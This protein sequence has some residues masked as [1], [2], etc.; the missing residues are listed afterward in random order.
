MKTSSGYGIGTKALSLFLSIL[1]AFSVV[2][3]GIV[4]ATE[5][6]AGAAYATSYPKTANRLREFYYPADT[7][8]VYE[9]AM[10]YS[11]KDNNTARKGLVN[12]G[13]TPVGK[14]FNTEDKHNS[15]YVWLG[16]KYQDSPV[17]TVRAFRVEV[18]GS[19]P[20]SYYSAINGNN[21][22]FYKVGSGEKTFVPNVLDGSVDLNSGTGDTA[23]L[24]LYATTDFNAGPPITDI[25]MF[26]DDDAS[27]A[28]SALEFLGYVSPNG[29][30]VTSFDKTA[31]CIDMNKDCSNGDYLYMG[32]KSSV[33]LVSTDALRA[34]M[35]EVAPMINNGQTSDELNAAMNYA[36]GIINDYN[37][38]SSTRRE[39]YSTVYDQEEID[40]ACENLKYQKEQVIA[41]S[42]SSDFSFVVPEA[43]YLDPNSNTF[44]TYINNNADGSVTQNTNGSTGKIYYTYSGADTASISY[45]FYDTSLTPITSDCSISL[46]S[47]SIAS[48]DA[49][50]VTINSG[51]TKS[52]ESG[53]IMW[54]LKYN[55]KHDNNVEKKAVAFTYIYAP[56]ITSVATAS[57]IED[58]HGNQ[59]MAWWSGVHSS[60][61]SKPTLTESGSDSKI[62]MYYG[63]RYDASS[64]PTTYFAPMVDGVGVYSTSSSK[65]SNN[66]NITEWFSAATVSGFEKAIYYSY[67]GYESSTDTWRTNAVTGYSALLTVDSSRYTNTSYIPNL[68][69]GVMCTDFYEAQTQRV[70]LSK[71]FYNVNKTDNNWHNN[72]L[73]PAIDN[74]TTLVSSQGNKRGKIYDNTVSYTWE[75]NSTGD[76]MFALAAENSDK[77]SKTWHTTRYSCSAVFQ[78]IK[79][80]KI[81]K[82]SLRKSVRT[83]ISLMP[84]FGV[85]GYEN[86][87]LK[88]IYFGYDDTWKDFSNAFKNASKALTKLDGSCKVA[89]LKKDLEDAI[90][91]LKTQVYFNVNHDNIGTNLFAP[92]ITPSG[93]SCGLTW[94]YDS[95]SEEITVNGTQSGDFGTMIASPFIPESGAT[96]KITVTK[97]GGS[98]TPKGCLVIEAIDVKGSNMPTRTYIAFSSSTAATWTF[99]GDNLKYCRAIKLWC[100]NNGGNSFTNFKFTIK[101]EKT[102][103]TAYSFAARQFIIGPATT[104]NFSSLPDGSR[105]AAR[106]GY[107]F[108]GWSTSPYAESGS[109][110]SVRVGINTTVY[111]SWLRNSSKL[112]VN[113][114]GGSWKGE[115]GN[116]TIEMQYLDELTIPEPYK[117]GYN[118]NG[119]EVT[120]SNGTLTSSTGET[121]TYVFGPTKDAVDTIKAKW[122]PITYTVSYNANGGS[123]TTASSSH[124]Y[125]TAKSLNANNFTRNYTATFK[126]NDGVTADSTGTIVSKFLGWNTA[127]D[128]TGT[129]Y[130]NNTNQG[131]VSVTNLTTV[132]GSTVPLYAK[133]EGAKLA[134]LPAPTRTG[135]TFD[136][137]YQNPEFTGSKVTTSTVFTKDATLYAR[138]IININGL[139]IDSHSGASQN[140]LV[141]F[142]NG[143]N[144]AS[145]GSTTN[146]YFEGSY[147]DDKDL[148]FSVQAQNTGKEKTKQTDTLEVYLVKG[149]KYKI[150]FSAPNDGTDFYVFKQ[151]TAMDVC[152]G[153]LKNP[154]KNNTT[155]LYDYSATFTVGYAS[156]DSDGGDRTWH[157]AKYN[158]DTYQLTGIY[159]M[160]MSVNAETYGNFTVSNMRIVEVSQD[161]GADN[162]ITQ[163]YGTTRNIPNPIRTG[164][165]FVNWTLTSGAGGSLS[166]TTGSN[167]RTT[168]SVY[169]FGPDKNKFDTI[170]ANW[171]PVTYS[172]SYNANRGSGTVH[173]S[174]TMANSTHTY[175][176]AKNLTENTYT[177]TNTVTY[178]L[179]GGSFAAGVNNPETVYSIFSGWNTKA[180][181]SGTSYDDL[182]SVKN[183]SSTQGAT[184]PLYAK[185]TYSGADCE[186]PNKTGYIFSG[187]YTGDNGTG[188]LVESDTLISQDMTLYAKWTPIIYY[189]Y[190]DY[191]KGSGSSTPTG[192]TGY[193]TATYDQFA[194]LTANGFSRA[195]YTFNGWNSKADGTGTSYTD[196]QSVKNLASTQGATVTLYAKWTANT[197]SVVYNANRGSSANGSG[198]TATSTHTYDT[199]K[200]LTAN[201]YSRSNT[202][203]FD[204]KG[205][206][207]G[208]SVASRT[209][210][211]T[212]NGWN[213]NAAGTGT[214]YTNKQ[215]VKNLASNQGATVNLYAKWTYGTITLPTPTKTGYL[216]EGWYKNSDCS[217]TAVTAETTYSTNLTLYAKWKAIRYSVFYE[218][219]RTD[220]GDASTVAG[221]TTSS[222]DKAYDD[223]FSLSENGFTRTI[224]LTYDTKGGDAITATTHSTEFAHW[225]GLTF[226]PVA[227]QYTY[228]VYAAQASV[229]KLNKDNNG[230]TTL[231]AEWEDAKVTLPTPVKPGYTFNY[232]CTDSGCTTA[233]TLTDGKYS[234][235][236]NTTIYAKW[237]ENTYNISYTCDGA[238]D[239]SSTASQTGIRYTEAKKLNANGFSRYYVITYNVNGSAADPVDA[240]TPSAASTKAVQSFNG[241]QGSVYNPSTRTYAVQTFSTSDIANNTYSKLAEG[242]SAHKT[243][244]LKATWSTGK[245]SALPT[246]PTRTGFTFDGW[247]TTQNFQSGTKVSTSTEFTSDTTVYAKWNENT[248]NISFNGNGN[249]SGTTAAMNGVR[250]TEEKTLTNGFKKEYTVTFRLNDSGT[251]VTAADTL[252]STTA[253]A[254]YVFAGW[255]ED[256]S[257]NGTPLLENNAKVSRLRTGS[258]TSTAVSFTAQWTP[259]SITL[260][261]PTR[262]GYVFGGWYK[263]ATDFSEENKIGNGGASYTPT[264]SIIIYARWTAINYTIALDFNKASVSPAT[265]QRGTSGTVTMSATFDKAK[266]LTE[267][268][269][270]RVGYK[271]AGWALTPSG[272]VKFSDKE[273]VKNLTAL[274]GATVTKSDGTSVVVTAENAREL[275]RDGVTVTLYA[276]WTPLS[277][278]I[279]YNGNGSSVTGTME[280][281]AVNYSTKSNLRMCSF[282]NTFTMDYNLNDAVGDTKAVLSETQRTCSYGFKGWA[283]TPTGA[284]VYT[285]GVKVNGHLGKSNF[286]AS[287]YLEG[288]D[289]ATIVVKDS[290]RIKV[291]HDGVW[292][293]LYAV[294]DYAEITLPTPTRTGYDFLGWYDNAG[295][296]GDALPMR[297]TP[298]AGITL[299]A[300]WAAHTYTIEYNGNKGNG[301]TTV[302]GTMNNSISATY[303]I[304]STL[305]QNAFSRDGYTFAGWNTKADGTGTAYANKATNVRNLTTENGV[306]VQLYAQWTPITYTIT[307]HD[308]TAEDKTKVQTFTFDKA[309]NLTYFDNPVTIKLTLYIEAG[310]IQESDGAVANLDHWKNQNGTYAYAPGASVVN[311]RTAPGNIDLYAD[312]GTGGCDPDLMLPAKTGYVF[313]GWY[314][315]YNPDTGVYSGAVHAAHSSFS[316]VGDVTLFAKWRPAKYNVAFDGN[317][318]T[319]GTAPSQINNQLYDGT[320]FTMPANSVSKSNKITFEENGGFAIADKTFN[321]VFAGWNTKAD[322]TGT[323]YNA[324]SGYNN[325][326]TDDGV[327][328]TLY[329]KWTKQSYTLPTPVKPG[330][331][332]KGWY[333][334]E[335]SGKVESVDLLEKN[336]TVEAKWEANNYSVTLNGN[337]NTNTPA[338]TATT[339]SFTYDAAQTIANPFERSFSFTLDYNYPSGYTNTT[340]SD[341]Y[342]SDFLGW[343][344][345]STNTIKYYS[346]ATATSDYAASA[347]NA[348]YYANKYGTEKYNKYA[349]V[350]HYAANTG[351]S[352]T[353]TDVNNYYVADSNGAVTFKNMSTASGATVKLNAKWQDKT[354]VLPELSLKGYIFGGWYD[355]VGCTG[356]K[357]EAGEIITIN[358]NKTF[359][360][361]WTPITYTIAFNGNNSTSGS[362]NSITNVAYDTTV[363]LTKN[364]YSRT[365]YV[366]DGW[367]T[368]ENGSGRAIADLGEARNLASTQGA[369]VTLFAQWVPITYKVVFSGNG[370]T[371]G[372]TDEI[373]P[374][375]YDENFVLSDNGFSRKIT[376]TFAYDN[377]TG[378]N[379]NA[380]AVAVATFAGWSKTA[381]GAVAFS[382]LQTVE[383]NLAST[384]GAVVTLHAKWNDGT[385][386][387]PTPTRI[388][389]TFDGWFKEADFRTEVKATDT[390][391][392]N[393]TIF[394]KWT[395]ITYYVAYDGNGNTNGAMPDKTTVTYDNEFTLASNAYGRVFAVSY[396]LNDEG[397]DVTAADDLVLTAANTVATATFAGWAKTAG[398]S[399]HFSTDGGRVNENLTTVKNETITLYAKWIDASVALPTPHRTGYTF[400]GWYTA[401]T[402]GTKVNGSTYKP[403]EDTIL[404]AHWTAITYTVAFNGNGATSGS[405]ESITPVKYDVTGTL[406]PNAFGKTGYTFTGWN[407]LSGGNGTAYSDGVPFKNLTDEQG[408]TITLYAQWAPITY[409]IVFEG[410]GAT[411][412]STAGINP[413]V[414]DTEYNLTAN[415][416]AREFKVTYNYN[417]ATSGTSPAEE[418][419]KAQFLAWTFNSNEYSDGKLVKNLASTQGAVVTLTAKWKDGS[420][421]LPSPHKIGYKFMGWYSSATMTDAD[422]VGGAGEPY[423]PAEETN[424]YAK[425]E[426]NPYVI[427]YH[428]NGATNMTPEEYSQNRTFDDGRSLT[429][430]EFERE[431]TVSYIY[432]DGDIPVDPDTA[433]ESASAPKSSFEGWSTTAGG[434]KAFENGHTGNMIT[435]DE[436]EVNL[437]AIWDDS[438]SFVILP[439][440]TRPGFEFLGWYTTDNWT[441]V[442]LDEYTQLKKFIFNDIKRKIDDPTYRSDPKELD[443]YT[444]PAG[445]THPAQYSESWVI[446]DDWYELPV[447]FVVPESTYYV[448]DRHNFDEDGDGTADRY[449]EWYYPKSDI[450][451]YARWSDTEAPDVELVSV[452]RTSENSYNIKFNL[453]DNEGITRYFWGKSSSFYGN[454]ETKVPE[455]VKG[456][457]IYPKQ[458]NNIEFTV[459]EAGIYYITVLDKTGNNSSRTNNYTFYTTTF[460]AIGGTVSGSGKML[461]Y[462]AEAE[463][464]LLPLPA[465]TKAGYSFGGWYSKEYNGTALD[466]NSYRPSSTSTIYAKWT[467]KLAEFDISYKKNEADVKVA[468]NIFAPKKVKS[469][470]SG[471]DVSYDEATGIITL[472]GTAWANT[473]ALIESPFRPAANSTYRITYEYVGGTAS[474]ADLVLQQATPLGT[475]IVESRTPQTIECRWTAANEGSAS[476]NFTY[477]RVNADSIAWLRLVVEKNSA[478]DFDNYQIRIKVEDITDGE[479]AYEFSPVAM[480]LDN[481]EAVSIPSAQRT[482]Y[483]QTG[484]Y[485]KPDSTGVLVEE[486]EPGSEPMILYAR[487]DANRYNVVYNFN[488]TAH[489]DGSTTVSDKVYTYDVRDSLAENTF[490]SRWRVNFYP[491]FPDTMNI[492]ETP[493]SYIEAYATFKGWSTTPDGANIVAD[494]YNLTA[495]NNAT[496]TLYA[497]WEAGKIELPNAAK[498]GLTLLGWYDKSADNQGNRIGGIGAEYVPTADI[499]LYAHWISLG[500]TDKVFVYD[501]ENG[502]IG[503][504]FDTELDSLEKG[505]YQI[506][507]ILGQDVLDH[508]YVSTSSPKS[509][510]DWGFDG[511][512]YAVKYTHLNTDGLLVTAGSFSS[513]DA[514]DLQ[515][516]S[517]FYLELNN[518]C[519]ST[520][521]TFY[522][523]LRFKFSSRE[524]FQYINGRITVVPA[525]SVYFEE[526]MFKTYDTINKE[527]AGEEWYNVGATWSTDT[528]SG[529]E[530]TGITRKNYS[531]YG[532]NTDLD[533]YIDKGVRGNGTSRYD[534]YYY[535]PAY[536]NNTALKATVD[537]NTRYS[538]MKE[539]EFEGK[540]FELVSECGPSTSGLM[541]YVWKN[542]GTDY[543]LI[544]NTL[545]DTRLVDDGALTEI[546]SN[547]YGTGES[548][549]C[550]VPVYHYS[551]AVRGKYLVQVQAIYLDDIQLQGSALESENNLQMLANEL[552]SSGLEVNEE[553]LDVQFVDEESV[554]NGGEA[555]N[556]RIFD[557]GI[558]APVSVSEILVGASAPNYGYIDGIRVYNPT[559]EEKYYATNERNAKFF[560]VVQTANIDYRY[561]EYT[562]SN[563]GAHE[564]NGMNEVYLAPRTAFDSDYSATAFSVIG[565]NSSSNQRVMIS[566]RAAKGSPTVY[567][568]N[569]QKVGTGSSPT[570]VMEIVLNH[571]TEMY[572]DVTNCVGSDGSLIIINASRKS[573]LYTGFAA[574]CNIKI[575]N[576]SDTTNGISYLV[577]ES[578]DDTLQ[579]LSAT[580]ASKLN[581]VEYEA[582][583]YSRYVEGEEPGEPDVPVVPDEPSEPDEP[584]GPSIPYVP[585]EPENPDEPDNP[586]VKTPAISISTSKT[587][588]VVEYR[589]KVN[590]YANVENLPVGGKVIWYNGTTPVGE[591]TSYTI[592]EAVSRSEITARVLRADGTFAA[593][594]ETITVTV[595]GG[596]IRELIAFFKKLLRMLPT[597]NIGKKQ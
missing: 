353:G 260:P 497:V 546:K 99:T 61:T 273:S 542:N 275:S 518:G 498:K 22:Y 261:T 289:N 217:G 202:I 245:I 116:T 56:Y 60:S 137:W 535:T 104:T 474:G 282:V 312:W 565:Y 436:P 326:T 105:I 211:S 514:D 193:V 570:K 488:S 17:D 121:Y 585:D 511:C 509:N 567:V 125:D 437:Y 454:D 230:E 335:T 453:S 461:T 142:K 512:D 355:N 15:N 91:G 440:P 367:N 165:H 526:D 538:Q 431:F 533:R 159:N 179:N 49:N 23:N 248:Y 160:R 59:I 199:A 351:N 544:S 77:W 227:K 112:T 417:G 379:T 286:T 365:G 216:F 459:D 451:L 208:N 263:S 35:A 510:I 191:N 327:T 63:K 113:P 386:S 330:Y 71:S 240:F 84:Q 594:T 315:G 148:T 356:T 328:V 382:N 290:D 32:Y 325:I 70:G 161:D 27:Y 55:D 298:T 75:K 74:V 448:G 313:E 560:N 578:V 305:E 469:S 294:W 373:N 343:T 391:S 348:A 257:A 433:P 146:L 588:Y 444:I 225:Y 428:G 424:L 4:P 581:I 43:I 196:K 406:T 318:H 486:I 52:I 372:S 259:A 358:A 234:F 527:D 591:G 389:Y 346:S 441:Q 203:T 141:Y 385:I 306:T 501:F 89:D 5:T 1:I 251:D 396:E 540:G 576:V 292:M 297:Y 534:P 419:A 301:S 435:D 337:G 476:Q 94:S 317:H 41:N 65:N 288:N 167:G 472:D 340:D 236:K 109:T 539:F 452:T 310:R 322:G 101:V 226:D 188:T 103:S 564:N 397:T 171:T 400:D 522:F 3:V 247:Y 90:T 204:Y 319:G 390:Y 455:T 493:P 341:D 463:E 85:I 207:G 181:G 117:E 24:T 427:N 262:L 177:R 69:A 285:D 174:G 388:G 404:Y 2:A 123:G 392:A 126:Y 277:Y 212:F 430:N 281:S 293:E 541:I 76:E 265:N 102:N 231:Y 494:A 363:N 39:G 139:Y 478:P 445:Y 53:Y 163:Q 449:E 517:K 411:K 443:S 401:P 255:K 96:Y 6:V 271:F 233:V 180:D 145:D 114:N 308:G 470:S 484:W 258:G 422:R 420:V 107:T 314:E 241:W 182:Q 54:T 537:E 68:K 224:K 434:E 523:E 556:E 307:F 100:W 50:G 29:A 304:Y 150:T 480:L 51:Y 369:T 278:Y 92:V 135:Y 62:T 124:T 331:T 592:D 78:P 529:T 120:G 554:L 210:T 414:Y 88:S 483:H 583:V 272:S 347:F 249:T 279:H 256:G 12:A 299:Y 439:Q 577:S 547:R 267:I 467:P 149:H 128:G 79:I 471:V 162:H 334:T 589:S 190:F 481:A 408:K 458:L 164:Y 87:Y 558:L 366:F 34:K 536:S 380:N 543:K 252:S 561:N 57:K 147:E 20:N 268:P 482:G 520:P 399:V 110:S 515:E 134:A 479:A 83:A 97:K 531:V 398:G 545:V 573:D 405:M 33:Q 464:N 201:G 28:K 519:L 429:P 176:T 502:T 129:L 446:P 133:W 37:E 593:S 192:N 131:A 72:T 172:V 587:T 375:T 460:E 209:A 500:V 8:F 296:T 530:N 122:T 154:V 329:A 115:A 73:K 242:T 504:V 152:S 66:K 491:Q 9:L 378:G 283:L 187:W 364:D 333:D 410:N 111:A 276:K 108:N 30:L 447:G 495:E 195:G 86:D 525:N 426:A 316:F 47:S 521:I 374:V 425:W 532:F 438:S 221:S 82:D 19:R 119:W 324:G 246:A 7:K 157:D 336:I 253:T 223:T 580:D 456:S 244:T 575:T 270:W 243:V 130:G 513:I 155:G 168:S 473:E 338:S 349:A 387:L 189:I 457:G 186:T 503:S 490:T 26:N 118:F 287:H 506:Q 98:Y 95:A 462:S 579:M 352:K 220:I 551:S 213:S 178:V 559:T 229:S 368:A 339:K 377:A 40:R 394:A 450:T 468:T 415:G 423:T 158:N 254:R 214:S 156:G 153:R 376:V 553:L 421:T 232:W 67:K 552:E 81:D 127:A 215:S 64:N 303:D 169:T 198:S 144:S 574:V 361:K 466:S 183:L 184:V 412:G 143:A 175:D 323:N 384:Q 14:N 300:K 357:H 235:N 492:L 295:C 106:T 442:E 238:K 496:I 362:M 48:G 80:T 284:V 571:N 569:S 360:A 393:T 13:Y 228:S 264:S 505:I 332:F 194:T 395:P 266:A 45:Q 18:N 42:F 590:F 269:Y 516:E 416:F 475:T 549:L 557:N 132:H 46:S 302:N 354:Y 413:A 291:N 383:E 582:P 403:T 342:D 185:W 563:S 166:Q 562:V 274:V 370:A 595:K 596:F 555:E 205:A 499:S 11:S 344:E 93:S 487:W 250:Y 25:E 402:G 371:E 597:V 508:N 485:T 321:Y 136:G 566:L 584:V 407:T 280:N 350:A 140:N 38:E 58:E 345:D 170:T 311:L 222:T 572:Y 200:A 432:N 31:D 237:T 218:G 151:G 197:Y 44:R 568:T 465:T 173:G 309:Q 16:V 381:G 36:I 507:L 489:G 206:D 409:S 320:N 524:N 477:S 586:V 21:S 548:F 359:Y 239:G 418:T 219:I 10:Y 138:W 550:Q 528:S